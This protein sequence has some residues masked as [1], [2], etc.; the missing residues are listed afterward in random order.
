MA[1]TKNG[2][3]SENSQIEE[4]GWNTLHIFGYGETQI[5]GS[6][7]KKV[8]TSSLKKV[9]AVIDYIYS[10]KPADNNAGSEYHSIIL[11]KNLSVRF[12]PK[13]KEEKSFS[14]DYKDLNISIIEELV[15]ELESI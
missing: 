4:K 10:L 13:S 9:Q 14:I 6:A 2:I 15:A 8:P 11:F 3:L 12:T 7:N 1:R 5:N